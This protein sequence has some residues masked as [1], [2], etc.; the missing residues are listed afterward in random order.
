MKLV[1]TQN[2]KEQIGDIFYHN[3]TAK[4]LD[5]NKEAFVTR[6]TAKNFSQFSVF[7]TSNA[8]SKA[9]GNYGKHF[10]NKQAAL[11]A[12]KDPFIL[13]IINEMPDDEPKP[14]TLREILLSISDKLRKSDN[15][16]LGTQLTMGNDVLN[17]LKF[18]LIEHG[19]SMSKEE[20]DMCLKTI[21]Q[22]EENVRSVKAKINVAL[23]VFS[24]N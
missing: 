11:K 10:I 13:A 23:S 7:Y 18:C 15:A 20:R 1:I 24:L 8:T 21:E 2:E 12:Y 3:I 17:D 9:Y 5:S 16:P 14:R 22:M 4:D 6:A 19:A